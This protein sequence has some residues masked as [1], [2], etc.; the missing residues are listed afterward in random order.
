VKAVGYTRALPIEDPESLLDLEQPEPSPSGRDLLVGVRAISVNPLDTKVR[1]RFQPPPGE[2][3]ILGWDASGVVLATGPEARLFRPGDEVWYAGTLSRSGT[4]A[5][6]HLVDERIVG[7]KPASLTHAQAAALPLTSLTAWE[8]LFERLGVAQSGEKGEGGSLL[9]IG[10]AGGVG[11]ILTQLARR[12]TRLTVLGTAS[13]PETREWV[14][15]LGAHHV[16]DHGR[17]LAGELRKA[18]FPDVGLVASLTRTDRHFAEIADLLAPWGRL[19]LIDD[20]APLDL[21]ALKKKSQSLHWEYVFTRPEFNPPDSVEHHRILC[22]VAG[23]V[24]AGLLRTTVGEHLG[25]ICAANLREA[26]ARIEGGHVKGKIV[27]EGF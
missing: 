1:T 3:R 23:A 19:A 11:S 9:I 8:L 27:L 10:A 4:N 15:G 16:L 13:R 17:P 26:H 14:L 24:D 6:L 18:G 5:E 22:E 20:P 21:C 12:L 25:R 7:R 2:T